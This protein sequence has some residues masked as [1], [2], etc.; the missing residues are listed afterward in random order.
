MDHYQADEWV[1]QSASCRLSFG[2]HT[3]NCH[4]D[5]RF[6]KSFADGH[7]E[8]LLPASESRLLARM[9]HFRAE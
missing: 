5:S 9:L 3:G 4:N 7:A 6:L 1:W 8:D 2:G